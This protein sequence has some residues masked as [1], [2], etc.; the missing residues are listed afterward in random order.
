M[1]E[2]TFY[3]KVYGCQMNVYDGDRLRAAMNGMGWSEAEE[4]DGADFAIFVTCSIRDK[5][6]QKVI[7]ELGRFRQQ[8]ESNKRPA[9]AVVGCMA[10]RT[11]EGLTRR[12]PWV[13]V[14]AGPRSLGAVP[15]AIAASRKGGGAVLLL[16]E[17]P[18]E[19][20]DLA[21]VPETRENAHKAYITISHGCDQFCS[22]CIVPYVRGRF[23]S[24]APGSVLEEAR[25]LVARGAGEI[26]LIGQ[27]V[28]SYGADFARDP[29]LSGY[30][31]A[32][33]LADVS[34]IEGLKRLRFTTSHPVDFTDDILDVMASGKNV[35][36]SINLPV[37]SGSDKVLREM[38]RKYRRDEY[39]AAIGRIR[40]ALP[41]VGL[42][43]DL[44]VGFPGES[45]EEFGES[46]SLLE[47]VRFDLVHTAAYSP[48]DGTPA[49]AR[50]DQVPKRDR[51][52]RLAAVN[53]IQA[54]ISAGINA[55]LVGETFEVLLDEA[56][57]K[58]E[59]LLQGRTVSDKVVLVSAPAGM[60]GTLRSVRITGS[61]A[62][63]LEGELI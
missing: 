57:P 31:F 1:S 63:C 38:N 24:R 29:K 37:Q 6:E 18:T 59:G 60:T 61:S 46:V 16:D 33:L 9:F 49:A 30:R 5:A 50:S 22:Y 26:T 54:R 36:P 10:Q 25:R 20:T 52:R 13:R 12:F 48:R 62:W 47:R 28:N 11:G 32:R 17:S 39:L 53:A 3:I 14:V 2:G 43:T 41:D 42:T 4:I 8:W 55:P 21:C 56:A 35:C 19:L 58:G 40:A 23:G 44:I 34:E 45:E 51:A 15:E 27:N 7:S